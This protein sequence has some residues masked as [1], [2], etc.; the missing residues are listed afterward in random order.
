MTN[1]ARYVSEKEQGRNSEIL[2]Q[3]PGQQVCKVAV[4]LVWTPTGP[5]APLWF[6]LPSS[7]PRWSYLY[8]DPSLPRQLLVSLHA[9]TNQHLPCLDQPLPNQNRNLIVLR[10]SIAKSLRFHFLGIS[11][12]KFSVGGGFGTKLLNWKCISGIN[13]FKGRIYF[14]S[15]N[16]QC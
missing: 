8:P 4:V 11:P 16:E 2:P 10:K 6:R 5:R 15:Y 14:V 12:P 1:L 7:L 13:S 9:N 3:K